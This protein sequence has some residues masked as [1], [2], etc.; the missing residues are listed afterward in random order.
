MDNRQIHLAGSLIKPT[1]QEVTGNMVSLEG[2]RFYKISNFDA[3][4]DFFLTVVSD[5]DLWLY[6]SSNGALTAGRKNRDNALFPYY[7]VDKIHDFHGLTGSRTVVLAEVEGK[8]YRWE[9]FLKAHFGVY[10]TT[11][12]LYKNEIGNKLLFEELNHDL[13]LAFQ[14]SWTHSEKYGIVKQAAL[15]QTAK[16]A[17]KVSI[18]DG[19]LNILPSGIDYTFQNEYSN[20]LDAY[21]RS[22]RAP[23]LPVAL[24]SL[25]SVPVDRAEPS[26][27]L[28]ATVGTFAGPAHAKLSLSERQLEAFRAGQP[29]AEEGE[30]RGQRC[31]F[32]MSAELEFGASERH[33]WLF[34]LDLNHDTRAVADH[35]QAVAAAADYKALVLAN[36]R[37]GGEN[38]R[39]IVAMGDGLQAT[40]SDFSVS[41]HY[42]NSL[43]NLMRGGVF[44]NNYTFPKSDFLAFVRGANRMVHARVAKALAEMPEQIDLAA[45]RGLA[46]SAADPDFER[47]VYEYLPLTFS[48]RHGDPSRPWNRFSIDNRGADGSHKY[49]FQGNWRDIFQNWEALSLSYPEFVESF[50]CKF[51]NAST[52]D[53]YN[54][55]RITRA[56]L[57]WERPEPDDPWAYIGYWGDH[58]IIYFQKLAEL[59]NQ[60]HPKR[61]LEMM[62]K[63]IFSFANVPYRI[64]RYA[65]IVRNPQDTI[66][67]DHDLH[68]AIEELEANLGSDAR[69]MFRGQKVLHVNLVEKLLVMLLAKLSNFVPEAGIWLNTQR[70]EWND[71]NNALVGNGASMVTLYYIRRFMSFWRALLEEAHHEHFS[72]SVEMHRFFTSLSEVFAKHSASLSKGFGDAERRGFVDAL[73]LAGEAYRETIYENGFSGDKANVSSKSLL[74]FFDKVLAFVDQ[75]IGANE[76]EDGLYHA[77]NLLA[78]EG[79]GLRIRHLYE[80]LEGQV[81]VLSA[82]SLPAAKVARL[83]DALRASRLYR[84]DQNSYLLYP[85]RALTPFYQKN[86]IP[87]EAVAGSALLTELLAQGDKSIV[88][89]DGRGRCHFDS[90][91]RNAAVL[92]EALDALPA[93]AEATFAARKAE[94]LAIYESLYDHQSFTGRSGTFFAYEGLGS[95]YWHMVSKLGLAVQECYFQAKAQGAGADL[96]GALAQ[97]YQAIKDGIGYNKSPK[98]YGAFPTDAYSHTPAHAG[99]QQPGL[100][101]QVKEDV[102]ARMAEL[103]VEVRG[104]RVSFAPVLLSKDELLSAPTAF[105]YVDVQGQA[106]EV[107]LEAK[108]L[109]FTFCQVPVVY[110]FQG[111]KSGGLTLRLADGKELE[112]EG[113]A[114]PESWSAEL[115]ARTGQVRAIRC[116]FS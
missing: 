12:N 75:S 28:R 3:M 49:D 50:I 103:G 101:G 80:M 45:L 77:Y 52:A 33:D 106:G 70:P 107:A 31:A 23:G 93:A 24:F 40:Q 78:F 97:H 39:R 30:V 91:F 21:K 76:R 47:A 68:H 85:D 114:L 38:L 116:Y 81:A 60:F 18:M 27:S 54:P 19:I 44:P 37:Q 6:I 109:A 7:S 92:A 110:A 102:I 48:R 71:A 1:P 86:I 113:H 72:L 74:E 8:T 65:E 9:P 41:R 84:A 20:L 59:S 115:F 42:Y 46:E 94:V 5:S 95:I 25:S 61:L 79:E 58:Q 104:G 32:F 14:Y 88:R 99:A 89:E 100:T 67:F 87:A 2:E 17:T 73:G 105:H 43:F 51:L 56:G 62:D 36:A 13:G 98:V 10:A 108:Q 66:L 112:F 90:R 26:E 16:K 69:L 83:L 96:L 82:M 53:G 57:D 29:V 35:C 11:R 55:Y 111:G 64:K 22:E 4:P 34:T 63:E 15:R